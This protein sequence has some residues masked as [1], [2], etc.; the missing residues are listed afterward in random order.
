MRRVRP[1]KANLRGADVDVLHVL[2]LQSGDPQRIRRV[3]DDAE[4]M[5]SSVVPHLIPLLASSTSA[6][7]AMR[8]L[9]TAA[10]HRPGV[11]IDALADVR[12]A[13]VV[14]RRVA[15]VMSHCR[16]PL[17]VSALLD[18][19]EDEHISV[20]VQCAR[21][22]FVLRRRHPE[23]GIA[24]DRVLELVRKEIDRGVHDIGLVF[25][26][27]A[28]VLPSAAIRGAYRSLRGADA[29]ARGFALEYLHGVLPAGIREKLTPILEEMG[30]RRETPIA[31]LEKG[32]RADRRTR[33]IRQG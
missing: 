16:S 10:V 27:L 17:V 21:T 25:T 22:L 23:L 31:S 18:G 2:A 19:C 20:R 29:H 6:L 30:P 4:H 28:L 13:S 3:L 11:L 8:A 12:L 15:R 32:P 24:G 26:F 5:S 9:R 14:R 33:H 1:E 7:D